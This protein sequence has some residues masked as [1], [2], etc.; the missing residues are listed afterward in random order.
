MSARAYILLHVTQGKSDLAAQVLR[1]QSGV[2]VIDV[3][4]DRLT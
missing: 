3:P 2:S 4:E 1:G